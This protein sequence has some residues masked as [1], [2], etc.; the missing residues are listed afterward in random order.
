MKRKARKRGNGEGSIQA[1]K[2]GTWRAVITIGV[3]PQTGKPRRLSKR[4]ATYAEALEARREL[5]DAYAHLDPAA[6][7][8]LGDYLR[9]WLRST[10]DSIRPRTHDSYK[11]AL[12]RHVI[13]SLGKRKLADLKPMQLQGLL[14]QVAE[15]VSPHTSNYVRTVLN[16]ALNEAVRWQVL[17]RNPVGH[18]RRKKAPT[19]QPT[20]WTPDQVRRFLDTA[21]SHRLYA[22]FYVLFATGLRHGELLGLSWDDITADAITVRRTVSTRSGHIVESEPKSAA[23]R[24]TVAIDPATGAVIEDHRIRQ[25]EELEA[26]GMTPDQTP[27]RVFTNR[28]GGTLDASNVTTVWHR[29]QAEAG[30]PRARLHDGRH[31]HLSMLVAKGID[32]RTVADRAGHSDSVLTLRQYAHALEAQRKRAAIPLDELL[33]SE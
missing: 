16:I 5:Q 10:Q 15:E 13:P 24:R 28:L 17:S 2:N 4:V 25:R 8:T 33:T 6:P 3:D 32:I 21:R 31:M 27:R 26:L 9:R 18:T 22:L 23:G 1:M 12:E 11:G 20:I 29:L 14:D 7:Q 30:V 19:R